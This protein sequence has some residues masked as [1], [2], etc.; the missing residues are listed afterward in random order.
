MKEYYKPTI[1][2]MTDRIQSY[3]QIEST[4][5]FGR[6][7]AHEY[8]ER[9]NNAYADFCTEFKERDRRDELDDDDFF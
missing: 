3:K 5:S 6:Q 2:M 7:I 8:I 9:A 4:L 1:Q